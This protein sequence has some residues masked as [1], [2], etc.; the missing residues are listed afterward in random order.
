MPTLHSLTERKEKK[1]EGIEIFFDRP[2]G[3]FFDKHG[4]HLYCSH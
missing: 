1:N 3:I 4:C 2:F